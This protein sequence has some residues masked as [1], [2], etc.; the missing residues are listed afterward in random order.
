MA[1]ALV[2]GAIL[3]VHHDL[4]GHG[5]LLL[6]FATAQFLTTA[7][8]ALFGR[9]YA[10]LVCIW[11]CTDAVFG[12]ATAL[13]ERSPAGM[14]RLVIWLPAAGGLAV[15]VRHRRQFTGWPSL[16]PTAHWVDASDQVASGVE[17]EQSDGDGFELDHP[18]NPPLRE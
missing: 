4:G 12:I 1:Q 3:E 13:G 8:V 5:L 18:A 15:W 14:I 6:E 16:P 7:S 2:V 10:R 9:P 11:L 17:P